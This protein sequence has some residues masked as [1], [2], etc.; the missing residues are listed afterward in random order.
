[1]LRPPAPPC[2]GADMPWTDDELREL[3]GDLMQADLDLKRKQVIWETPRNIVLIV[4]AAAGIAGVLGFKLG[5]REPQQQPI[6]IQLPAP[7]SAPK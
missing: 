2:Y 5:Q 7:A 6:V 1:M 4:A 3:K